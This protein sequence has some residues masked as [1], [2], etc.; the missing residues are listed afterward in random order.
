ML[1]VIPGGCTRQE[2]SHAGLRAFQSPP[3]IVLIHDAVRPFV[4]IRILQNNIEKA[5]LNGAVDTCIPSTDTLI[6]APDQQTIQAI[7]KRSD[8]L[9]GQTPQTFQYP[10]ILKAHEHALRQK[11]TNA[12]DDCQLILTLGLPVNITRGSEKNFKITSE[13]DLHLA[14]SLGSS[15]SSFVPSERPFAATKKILS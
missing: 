11:I 13:L 10:L 8:Y 15:Q 4:S 7:P 1:Q 6:F 3:D 14:K 12:T 2:S 5:I 9:R